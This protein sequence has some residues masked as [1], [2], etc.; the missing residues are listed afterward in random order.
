MFSVTESEN[1]TIKGDAFYVCNKYDKF[2]SVENKFIPLRVA[3]GNSAFMA[4][5]H[6]LQYN[7]KVSKPRGVSWT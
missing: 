2:I 1:T 7:S 3:V 5:A 4:S 6:F